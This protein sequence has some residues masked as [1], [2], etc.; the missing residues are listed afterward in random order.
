MSL[1]ISTNTIAN[2][3]RNTLTMNQANLQKSL[4]R[5]SS[6]SKLIHPSD[7]A[8]GLSVATKLEATL[9]RNTRTQQNVQNAISFLQV[10]D[11]ALS[12][13]ATILDRMSELK[14][15]SLDPTKNS[16]DLTNYDT[17]FTQLQSQL[18]NIKNEDFNS[19][20]LFNPSSN[21]TVYT[22]ESGDAAGE[23]TV[24]ATRTG[25]FQEI[26]NITYGGSSGSFAVQEYNA[27]VDYST[28]GTS[29]IATDTTVTYVK[30]TASDGTVRLGYISDN[31]GLAAA[32]AAADMSFA[33]AVTSGA[34]VEISNVDAIYDYEADV[35]KSDIFR[36]GNGGAGL[37][38]HAAGAVVF[39]DASGEFYISASASFDY[40]GGVTTAAATINT[41]AGEFKKLGDYIAASD[42]TAYSTSEAY[43]IGDVVAD[44]SNLYVASAA[45]SVGGALPSGGGNWVQLTSYAQSG[46]DLLTTSNTLSNYTVGDFQTFIQATATARGQ[47]GAEAARL[48]SSI[49]MLKANQGSLDAARSR[50][51]D[52]DIALES[53]NLAKQNIL[54]QSA[55]AMLVQANASQNIA[56][57][58]LG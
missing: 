2:T 29:E 5:L 33:D 23:P 9:N 8:G 32:A 34:I 30:S 4:A 49:E 45:I 22:T 13:I 21:L 28:G 41:T 39:D 27:K 52:V 36:A 43:E 40:A 17:E 16:T 3:V 7:D 46:S 53:T 57:Q 24:T 19:I 44:G 25:V 54:V 48:E 37:S 15:M 56:L 6:G 35:V 58:L 1:V 51:A 50:L 11:G 42:Y 20:G 18:A 31:D 55:A 38:T 14:V 10:Q 47:N 26:G 12:Q